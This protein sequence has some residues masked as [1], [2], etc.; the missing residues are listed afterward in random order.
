MNSR[1]ACAGAPPS[2]PH[3]HN[4]DPRVFADA[5]SKIE[6]EGP[7]SGDGEDPRTISL[8]PI[9]SSRSFAREQNGGPAD[10]RFHL[11]DENVNI[12]PICI[13]PDYLH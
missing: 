1:G 3:L 8:R 12:G 5:E 2:R 6:A 7:S 9:D 13:S 4:A 10:K 11:G